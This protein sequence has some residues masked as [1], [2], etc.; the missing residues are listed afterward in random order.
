MNS[1]MLLF[2]GVVLVLLGA[3]MIVGLYNMNDDT[4][5]GWFVALIGAVMIGR[6][7]AKVV[8]ELIR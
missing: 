6:V 7:V 2:G 3:I 4:S 1:I 5:F 8:K